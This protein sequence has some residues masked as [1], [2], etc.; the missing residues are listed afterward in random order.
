MTTLPTRLHAHQV[1]TVILNLAHLPS[2]QSFL[3][4]ANLVS[5]TL[6]LGL[7]ASHQSVFT[8]LY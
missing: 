7:A 4:L 1:S 2:Q 6:T 8:A 5:S 3:L